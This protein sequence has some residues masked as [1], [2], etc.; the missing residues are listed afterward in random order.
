MISFSFS[1]TVGRI[2]EYINKENRKE[3]QFRQSLLEMRNTKFD[4]ASIR[5]KIDVGDW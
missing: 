5:S 2:S 1:T 4:H 3:I